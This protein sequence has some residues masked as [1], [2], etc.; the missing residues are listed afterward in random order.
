M[1]TESNQSTYRDGGFQIGDEL[2]NV[3]GDSLRGL[4]MR[5]VRQ[6]L[7]TSGPQVDIIIARDQHPALEVPKTDKYMRSRL[8]VPIKKR[9][10]VV[11]HNTESNLCE[12]ETVIKKNIRSIPS[13]PLIS[14]IKVHHIKF[15]KGPGLPGLGFTIVGGTDSP[16]G[17]MGIFVRSIFP[18]GQ[19]YRAQYP[20]LREGGSMEDRFNTRL[21][22]RQDKTLDIRQIKKHL[23]YFSII[24]FLSYF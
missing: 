12:D 22:N 16:K 19:A 11:V 14:N 4:T 6:I 2:V 1:S 24:S 9:K 20:G 10:E 15:V 3:N 5:E 8:A 13:R 21:G 23:L 18:D 17:M 7:T